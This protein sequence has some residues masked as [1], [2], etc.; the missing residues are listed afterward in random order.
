MNRCTSFI[1][2]PLLR[3]LRV[4]LVLEELLGILH[5][6]FEEPLDNLEVLEKPQDLQTVKDTIPP[7]HL[8]FD[9]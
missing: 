3:I 9:D 5:D 8:L 2:L 6:V 1:V 4:L 7:L